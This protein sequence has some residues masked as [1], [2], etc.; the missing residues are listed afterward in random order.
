MT[1]RQTSALDD[2]QFWVRVMQCLSCG[3]EMRLIAVAQ[4]QQ[5]S[6]PGYMH[7]TFQCAAC[8]EVETRFLFSRELPVP[9]AP[10]AAEEIKR[11]SLWEQ[12][13]AKLR[14]HQVVLGVEAE[15][16]KAS[17]RA[18]EFDRHWDQLVPREKPKP[19]ARKRAGASSLWART[20]AKL[21]PVPDSER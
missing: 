5:L 14:D 7:H 3:G 20:M 21:R 9:V 12:A 6:L 19:R 1:A 4:D 13:I 11:N 8:N 16:R 17:H 10:V 18:A 15:L 2:E